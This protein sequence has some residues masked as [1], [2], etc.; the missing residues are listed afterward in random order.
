VQGVVRAPFS[1]EGERGPLP[2]V[3]VEQA[4]DARRIEERLG[5]EVRAY[6]LAGDAHRRQQQGSEHTAADTR[7]ATGD[8]A[9]TDSRF[10]VDL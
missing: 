2:G 4:V 9:T 6:L 3:V 7:R 10:H 8:S 5:R 1:V